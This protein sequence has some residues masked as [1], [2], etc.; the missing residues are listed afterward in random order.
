[1][2]KILVLFAAIIACTQLVSND[3]SWSFP[4]DTLSNS[5]VN[6]TD[7]R[8]VEDPSGNLVSVWVESGVVKAK[9]KLL[10]ASWSSVVSL[11]GSNSSQPRVVVDANG[12]ATAIWNEN[13]VIKASSKPFG[14]SWTSVVSI[15]S[16]AAASP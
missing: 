10:N 4:P 14:G 11:S 6:A 12:N 16:G 7:P 13:G 8:L 3:I 9:T 5:G 15:S 1:M 2:K